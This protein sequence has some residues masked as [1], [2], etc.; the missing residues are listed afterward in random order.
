MNR[1]N[2]TPKVVVMVNRGASAVFRDG[3]GV[4]V[5]IVVVVDGRK[6]ETVP[7]ERNGSRNSF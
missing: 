4:S 5:V 3:D 7:E 2:E 6:N 1:V